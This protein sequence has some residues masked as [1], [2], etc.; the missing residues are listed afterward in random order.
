MF[1]ASSNLITKE[2]Y[3]TYLENY[4]SNHSYY[5]TDMILIFCI[6]NEEHGKGKL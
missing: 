1:F 4:Q 3:V 5:L 6:G 2:T